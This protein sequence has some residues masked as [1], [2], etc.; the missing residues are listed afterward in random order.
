[1]LHQGLAKEMS[2]SATKS[3][4]M[5]H[6]K[7]AFLLFLNSTAASVTPALRPRPATVSAAFCHRSA[8]RAS[9]SRPNRALSTSPHPIV[10]R[11]GAS[12]RQSTP[13]SLHSPAACFSAAL[14]GTALAIASSTTEATSCSG[15]EEH[16]DGGAMQLTT[17][18]GPHEGRANPFP[19]DTIKHDTYNGVTVD[20]SLLPKEITACPNRFQE[21]LITALGTW[22]DEGKRGVWM[23]IP[24][25]LAGLIPPCTEQGFDFQ[26][27]EP[28]RAV[29]TKW[30]P[31][32]SDSRL[33]RGP[34]HQVGVGILLLHPQT[35]KMLA[36]QEKTGPAA[37]R[38]LWKMPTGLTDPGE[39]IV[40]AA[41]R[42]L[43]EETGLDGTFDKI[44]C[45]RQAHG[46]LFNQS[47]MFFVCLL[48]LDPKYDEALREGGDIELAPQEEEIADASWIDMESYANQ[49]VWQAS[50]LYKEMND[51]MLSVARGGIEKQDSEYGD[52]TGAAAE[53]SNINAHGGSSGS[54]FPRPASHG[55]GF[56]ARTL[57]VGF[58]PGKNTIYTS[59]L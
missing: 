6:P 54:L 33:P 36:V 50:P 49:E 30:L 18:A 1:M 16:N 4:T 46:G 26:H 17:E 7:S 55:G 43:K 12:L 45:F 25:E 59:N 44:I 51:A 27:A 57:P 5:R 8:S 14:A 11:G 37:A 31:T 28:G 35:G 24:T 58:R 38:K 10:S 53:M 34:T 39:D 15:N 47:D 20:V 56:V 2:P 9:T 29:L 32:E 19:E 21:A 40:E 52:D 3:S 22:K 23:R 42:E 13:P 48:R 41:V